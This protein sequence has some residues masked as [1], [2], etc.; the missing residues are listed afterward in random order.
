MK[1]IAVGDEVAW[2]KGGTE[3]G[4]TVVAI[5]PPLKE[6]SGYVPE[7]YRLKKGIRGIVLDET[8]L[9][10]VDGRSDLMR[11]RARQIRVLRRRDR[12]Q[13]PGSAFL[14]GE[15]KTEKVFRVT[16]IRKT[17]VCEECIHRGTRA[18]CRRNCPGWKH[19]R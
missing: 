2:S 4:G 12:D 1:R 10:A 7:G 13:V 5:V 11:P 6:A 17:D 18:G 3:Y 8:P 15:F 14:S 19:G 9:V 16:Q